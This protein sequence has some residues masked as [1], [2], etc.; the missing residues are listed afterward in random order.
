M[1]KNIVKR[2][3]KLEKLNPT[4]RNLLVVRSDGT[5][6]GAC[7]QR[8]SQQ[9]FHSWVKTQD[10]NTQVIIVCFDWGKDLPESG[11]CLQNA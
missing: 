8:L 2:L 4:I 9:E 6:G 10:N 1:V 11:G 3:S 7:G 5:Y